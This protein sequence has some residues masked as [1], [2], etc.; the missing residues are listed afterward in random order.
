MIDY[1]KFISGDSVCYPQ[2][3]GQLEGGALILHGLYSVPKRFGINAARSTFLFEKAKLSF[4]NRL[5]VLVLDFPEKL[6]KAE[7]HVFVLFNGN[8]VRGEPRALS[9]LSSNFVPWGMLVEKSTFE[10]QPGI[11]Y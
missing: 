3:S 8:Q 6:N 2:C 5:S 1:R 7:R 10:E 9:V 4:P 11:L